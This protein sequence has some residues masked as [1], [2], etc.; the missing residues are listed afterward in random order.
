M[1][2]FESR[3][4]VARR[5]LTSLIEHVTVGGESRWEPF[6]REVLWVRESR[7][8]CQAIHGGEVIAEFGECH[9]FYGFLTSAEGSVV[10]GRQQAERYSVTATS[11]LSI[12]AE[13]EIVEL[14]ALELVDLDPDGFEAR[15][16]VRYREQFGIER[17]RRVPDGWHLPL[18]SPWP[19]FPDAKPRP[20]TVIVAPW[21]PV[22]STAALELDPEL[23]VA[24]LRQRWGSVDNLS[25]HER[26]S[27]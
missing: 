12:V 13:V 6:E 19:E 2:T 10:D 3:C 9:D 15:N 17:Y 24:V 4:P 20:D 1:N 27:Q 14:P 22:W 18:P 26:K 8:R 7:A 11:S 16:R 25:E 21:A 23:V 5:E